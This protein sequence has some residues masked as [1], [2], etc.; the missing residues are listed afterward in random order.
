MSKKK[1]ILAVMTSILISV[2][3]VMA[4]ASAATTVGNNIDI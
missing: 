1:Q 4:G 2:G 3:L